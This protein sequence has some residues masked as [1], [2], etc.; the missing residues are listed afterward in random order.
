MPHSA[1]SGNRG[2]PPAALGRPSAQLRLP[3]RSCPRHPK[4]LLSRATRTSKCVYELEDAQVAEQGQDASRSRCG[5][6][7]IRLARGLHSL[8]RQTHLLILWFSVYY[9]SVVKPD[10]PYRFDAV[11]T[12]TIALVPLRGR[13]RIL[14]LDP[15]VRPFANR[16]RRT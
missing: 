15:V 2:T 16:A 12:E 7:G 1:V 11:S 5:E 13:A 9:T 3:S 8:Q 6:I 14:R 4:P 10:V